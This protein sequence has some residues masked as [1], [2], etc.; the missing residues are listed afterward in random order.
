ME[1]QYELDE[2]LADS[3]VP[4][5]ERLRKRQELHDNARAYGWSEDILHLAM[6]VAR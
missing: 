5:I 2:T 1:V 3:L 4:L 6:D